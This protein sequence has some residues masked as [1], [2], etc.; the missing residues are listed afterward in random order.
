[1]CLEF[2][3]CWA[4]AFVFFLGHFVDVIV[5]A[6]G[7]VDVQSPVLGG[8]GIIQYLSVNGLIVLLWGSPSCNL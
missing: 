8:V 3:V 6:E 1:L 4:A 5:L 2:D 7:F